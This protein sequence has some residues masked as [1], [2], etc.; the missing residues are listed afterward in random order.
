M[1]YFEHDVQSLLEF[2]YLFLKPHQF[3]YHHNIGRYL[4]KKYNRT[5]V[6]HVKV[7]GPSV[8]ASNS[9]DKFDRWIE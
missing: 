5:R 8:G 9:V 7:C 4:Y 2:W 6:V 1:S 3:T